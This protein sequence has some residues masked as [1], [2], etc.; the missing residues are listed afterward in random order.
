[1]WKNKQEYKAV[2]LFVLKLIELTISK[3]PEVFLL[4][5]F[6]ETSILLND[7][8]V[9]IIIPI[10]VYRNALLKDILFYPRAAMIKT[11]TFTVI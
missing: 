1:L 2:L 7:S 8:A 6:M 5:N 10:K 4:L 9:Y 3:M 11:I